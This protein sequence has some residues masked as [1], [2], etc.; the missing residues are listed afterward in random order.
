MTE[1]SRRGLVFRVGVALLVL[2]S[3]ALAAIAGF[4]RLT[5]LDFGKLVEQ[6]RK[7][8]EQAVTDNAGIEQASR[9]AQTKALDEAAQAAI[10]LTKEHL[11]TASWN[12]AE[13][14]DALRR[15]EAGGWPALFRRKDVIS[16]ARSRRVGDGGE[17]FVVDLRGDRI[18][19]HHNSHLQQL[20][21]RQRYPRIA[22]ALQRVRWWQRVESQIDTAEVVDRSR[23]SEIIELEAEKAG[24]VCSVVALGGPEKLS[25]IGTTQIDR[26]TQRVLSRISEMLTKVSAQ[27]TKDYRALLRRAVVLPRQFEQQVDLLR[28][29]LLW[30]LAI[31]LPV[32]IVTSAFILLFLQGSVVRPVSSMV[33]LVDAVR[34]GRYDERAA[35]SVRAVEIETL[36]R[37]LNAM[38]DRLV[39]L[40]RT[41]RSKK[42]L[43][44]D[45]MAILELVST[46][47]NGD[48][49]VR[50]RVTSAEMGALTDALNHMLESIGEL[51]LQVRRSGGRVDQAAET[52]VSSSAAIAAA[53]DE[54]APIL[55]RLDR[56]V[57]A[58]G[59]RALEIAQIVELVDE[60]SAQTN[61]LALNAAIEA[62]RAGEL[63]QGFGA[64]A[65]EVRKLAERA[66]EATKDVS[67]FVATIQEATQEATATIDA[68]RV[69]VRRTQDSVAD[70][71]AGGER[72]SAAIEQLKQAMGRFKI[73]RTTTDEVSR[74][75]ELRGE[76]LRV[77]LATVVELSGI[78]ATSGPDAKA[79]AVALL[80]EIER[81][82][83]EASHSIGA[84]PDARPAASSED[85]RG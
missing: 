34:R 35:I 13:L 6:Q 55:M 80:S 33:E 2:S 77:A 42:Q 76:E 4:W 25:L 62:S 78:A 47:A 7:L 38:L 73:H 72:M 17:L 39:S 41:E 75:L 22:A 18:V 81:L 53:S 51:L 49:T 60:I 31:L 10:R 1:R 12:M 54:Q 21:F 19:L 29:R 26:G 83:Q 37:A 24:T 67:A 85:S 45:L 69:L 59:E 50:G 14:L 16:L 64:V 68:I 43:E 63:G 79:S 36:S 8:T 58:M 44:Q 15:A 40:I 74:A 46:A 3:C 5:S 71:R 28:A 32:I 48:L 65:D 20:S 11:K 30:L 61:M 56:K 9:R 57:R 66:G 82:T 27:T 84:S 23:L 70:N 52:I